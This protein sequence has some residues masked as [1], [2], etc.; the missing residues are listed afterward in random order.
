M[1]NSADDFGA[2]GWDM[3]FGW[4]YFNA[5][6]AQ[7]QRKQYVLSTVGI[8]PAGRR[9]FERLTP[10]ATKATL[11]WHR[12]VSPDGSYLNDLDLLL[13]D[14]RHGMLQDASVSAVD[15]VEQITSELAAPAVLV[16]EAATVR[17][18]E[19]RFALAHSGGFVERRGP[20]VQ[21]HLATMERPDIAAPVLVTATIT[22]V[23][24][25]R[26]HGYEVTLQPPAGASL[27]GASASRRLGSLD[28]GET[29]TVTWELR[30][31]ETA[32][33]ATYQVSASAHAYGAIWTAVAST[34]A[35]R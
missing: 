11:V 22:N 21:V 33:F 31:A 35:A 3:D 6:N 7:Q 5:R 29:A 10:A 26:G 32:S 1:I 27:V 4:G 25:L 9:F 20:D 30:V 19:E 12:H 34:R 18:G 13:Y 2:A 15:N 14:A 24:D 23:G 16:V 17:G 28:P 8:A